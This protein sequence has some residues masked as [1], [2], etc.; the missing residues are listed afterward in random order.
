MR[1]RGQNCEIHS[2]WE[3]RLLT[4]GLATTRLGLKNGNTS[5]VISIATSMTRILAAAGHRGLRSKQR[6]QDGVEEDC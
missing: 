6:R 3:E 4:A 1:S 5:L 2:N